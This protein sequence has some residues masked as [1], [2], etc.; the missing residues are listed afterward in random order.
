MTRTQPA[1]GTLDRRINSTTRARVAQLERQRT[2][3]ME[4]LGQAKASQGASLMADLISLERLIANLVMAA[5][6]LPKS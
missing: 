4:E 6:S 1:I 3:L 5:R 2:E